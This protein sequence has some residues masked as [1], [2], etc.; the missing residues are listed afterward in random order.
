MQGPDDDLLGA[1]GGPAPG[2]PPPG[3]PGG[4]GGAVAAPGGGGGPSAG[5]PGVLPPQASPVAQGAPP[6]G[7]HVLGMNI[8]RQVMAGLHMA[9]MLMD[10]RSQEAKHA[11]KMYR[12]GS[13]Y[14]EPDLGARGGAGA[15]GG[16]LRPPTV[17]AGA[18][19]AAGG[20][21]LAGMPGAAPPRGPI[22]MA[23]P[24][25]GAGGAIARGL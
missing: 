25:P 13:R 23:A 9:R 20:P 1:A 12:D 21:P 11:D 4:L 10:P 2:A 22:A 18:A 17:G 7:T 24:G 19:S 16:P 5:R 15:G 8:M 14:W 3:P 6:S